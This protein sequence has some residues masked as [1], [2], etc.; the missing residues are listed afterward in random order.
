MLYSA[1]ILE[2]RSEKLFNRKVLAYWEEN[3]SLRRKEVAGEIFFLGSV[4]ILS[5]WFSKLVYKEL[6][7][8]GEVLQK[9]NRNLDC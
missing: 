3:F 9:A 4:D 1:E 6:H 5:W 2:A 7:K 8:F